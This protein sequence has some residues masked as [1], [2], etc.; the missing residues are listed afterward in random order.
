VSPLEVQPNNALV[1]SVGFSD[2]VRMSPLGTSGTIVL[3]PD[4]R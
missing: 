1:V 2:V 4:N 3:A